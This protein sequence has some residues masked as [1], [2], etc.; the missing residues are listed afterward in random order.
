MSFTETTTI[1]EIV[2]LP[3][4]SNVQI[5]RRTVIE[6]DGDFVSSK[7]HYQI[8]SS[9][10]AAA[11]AI[12][13]AANVKSIADA[14]ASAAAKVDAE[15]ALATAQARIAELEAQVGTP[16]AVPTPVT[17]VTPR[18]MRQAL[19][20]MGLRG[21]VEAAVA[22]AD[23]DLQDWWEYSN[24]FERERPQVVAMAQALGVSDAQLDALWA[25][26]ATL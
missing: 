25:L 19:T 4:E 14:Q 11:V 9:D 22:A 7:D 8:Y 20:Q 1:Q 6:K 26:A 3:L 24:A 5:K 17:S 10:D 18:Q 12:V 16:V 23:Q 21:P 13:Q 2:I 15:A